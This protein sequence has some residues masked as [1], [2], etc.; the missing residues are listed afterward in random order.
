MMTS[1][2]VSAILLS[3][4]ILKIVNSPQGTPIPPWV[5]GTSCSSHPTCY[6][7]N[8]KRTVTEVL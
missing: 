3:I 2:V 4:I 6:N 1:E 5:L 8:I 7:N